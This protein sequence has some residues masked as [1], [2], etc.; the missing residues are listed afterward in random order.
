MDWFCLEPNAIDVDHINYLLYKL[1]YILYFNMKFNLVLKTKSLI[2]LFIT[3]AL[4]I[5]M[6][7]IILITLF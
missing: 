6:K 3:L 7:Y 1:I 5:P 2:T 4:Q